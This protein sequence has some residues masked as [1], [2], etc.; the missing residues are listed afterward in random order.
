MGIHKIYRV[1]IRRCLFLIG[2]AAAALQASTVIAEAVS[3]TTIGPTFNGA[4]DLAINSKG[5]VFVAN[6]FDST[7]TRISPDGQSSVFISN[8]INGASGNEFDDNDMLYQ[9]NFA[10][11][12]VSIISPAGGISTFAGPGNG[13]VSPVG[14]TLDS[15][16]VVYVA[17]CGN[18]TITR[19]PGAGNW[20][21]YCCR[22]PVSVPKRNYHG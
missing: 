3:V 11:N 6:F 10:S 12:Q 16:G 4:G 15:N 1:T 5:E 14:V 9:S 18:N 17:N 7:I 2:C 13:I 21:G 20:C 19:H 8:G 22:C